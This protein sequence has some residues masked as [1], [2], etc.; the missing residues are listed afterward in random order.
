MTDGRAHYQLFY[1]PENITVT[2]VRFVLQT[3]GNYVADAYNGAKLYR[4]TGASAFARLDSTANNGDF[5]RGS[6]VTRNDFAFTGGA[7]EL[8]AG[9]YVVGFVWN[10]SATT[11]APVMYTSFNNSSATNVMYFGN[12][13]VNQT[14]LSGYVS[15]QADL[16]VNEVFNDLTSDTAAWGM[17]LY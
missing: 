17:F 10:A 13:G 4:V 15:S 5:W 8:E 7:R 6:A 14:K 3:Q 1:I 9:L 2:G 16:A 12:G 11:A